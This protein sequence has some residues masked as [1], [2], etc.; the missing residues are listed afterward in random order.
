MAPT[1]T[2]LPAASEQN[3][4]LIEREIRGVPVAMAQGWSF[5]TSVVTTL[6][7]FLWKRSSTSAR[8][9]RPIPRRRYGAAP[10][11]EA[12]HDGPDDASVHL[13]NEE[14]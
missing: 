12:A 13:G 9:A 14:F 2:Q 10:P 8:S 5:S 3:E 4:A 7:P 1:P 6:T 11:V